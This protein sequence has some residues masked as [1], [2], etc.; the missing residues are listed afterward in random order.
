MIDFRRL[1]G[2]SGAER[3]DRLHIGSGSVALPGWLNIDNQAYPGVDRVVDVTRGLPFRGVRFIFAEHF[4]EHLRFEDARVLLA[5]CRRALRRGG[6][7]R[8]STPNLD[9]VW[10]S[11]YRQVLTPELEVLACFG[12][13]RAFRGWG[14]QFLWNLATLTS[15]LRDAGFHDVARCAYGQSEHEELRGLEH[16][17]QNEDWEGHSH[18]LIVEAW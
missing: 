4:L 8:L 18:I 2:R 9:W 3:T 16:H 10:A 14:H 15:A 11:H 13:N 6:V 7:L 12:M 5:D 17:E 1:L